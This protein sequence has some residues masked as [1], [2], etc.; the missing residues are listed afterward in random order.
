VRAPLVMRS[1]VLFILLLSCLRASAELVE[2]RVVGVADGDTLRLLDDAHAQHKIRIA[3]IDAPEHDQPFGQR[4]KQNLSKL[5]FGKVV[6]ADCY[7]R[8]RYGRDVCT[9]YVDG[10]DVGLAQLDAGLAWW[11]RRYAREQPRKQ[12]NEYELAEDRASAEREGL[13]QDENPVP[14]WEWRRA[15]Q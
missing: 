6:Q 12:R 1:F 5:A 8:D 11:F 3:G 4:S 2:G 13:W 15:K 7:K 9:V 14:P 10:K